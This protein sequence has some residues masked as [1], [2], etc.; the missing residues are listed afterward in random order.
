MG[1]VLVVAHLKWRGV[2][3]AL[4]KN[5]MRNVDLKKSGPPE[6]QFL[7]LYCVQNVPP[8]AVAGQKDAD[9]EDDGQ[10]DGNHSQRLVRRLIR[11]CGN[12]NEM[13]RVVA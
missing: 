2:E 11:T 5:R 1:P 7:L 13:K 10:D 3:G 9:G 4:T 12:S 6:M 8:E